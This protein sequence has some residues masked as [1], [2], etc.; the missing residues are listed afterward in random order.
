MFAPIQ[1]A[2]AA[3]LLE[4]DLPVPASL[5]TRTAKI[6]AKRFAVHRNNVIVG[7]VDALAARFPATSRLVGEEFFRAMARVYVTAQPPR[8]P[9]LMFYGD[10][11]PDFI[12]SFAPAAEVIYLVGVARLEAAR[13]HAYHA[14]D[15]DPIDPAQ[16]DALDQ[17]ALDDLRIVPHPSAQIVRSRYPIVTIWAMNVGRKRIGPIEDWSGEDA[18][19]VRP[20][21]DVEV[22]LLPPG[23]ASFL[24]ALFAGNT[25]AAAVEAAELE[26]ADFDLVINIAALI[27]AGVV[28]SASLPALPRE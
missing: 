19:V 13:T 18:L 6:P 16:L 26:S 1:D 17:S 8:S 4:A 12:A 22:R 2:F 10:S 25:L 11:F 27:E 7:L 9:M 21:L 15:A 23:G 28:S 24:S 20:R 5:T 14:V 3:A